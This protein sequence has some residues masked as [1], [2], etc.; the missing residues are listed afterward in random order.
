MPDRCAACGRPITTVRARRPRV[1]LDR[2]WVHYSWWANS[3]HRAIP[4]EHGHA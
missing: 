4:E 3:T 1:T 2:V